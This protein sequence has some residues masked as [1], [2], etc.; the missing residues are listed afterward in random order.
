M[1]DLILFPFGGNA[2]EAV[3]VIEEINKIEKKWNLLGFVDD[4][5]ELWGKEFMSYKVLGGKDKISLYPSAKILAVPGN[6]HNYYRR[7]RIIDSLCLP[8]DRFATL[9][10]PKASIGP[11]T[12]I[13]YNTLIMA[14]VVTTVNVILGHSCVILPNT[15]ISHDST[16]G[17]LC[18][19]GSNISVSGGVK[20]ERLCYIGSGSK[21][22]QDITVRE[23]TLIGLGTV[24]LK[25]TEKN[26]LIA[27]S[28]GRLLRKINE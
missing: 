23:K 6:P 5:S 24:L 13:G 15:V 1:E 17:D 14:G 18:L 4:N 16:I 11:D 21:L 26:S 20:V 9:I 2:K 8:P 27:G 12:L 19:V 25:S 22:I 3:P 28:P 10:H 7:D